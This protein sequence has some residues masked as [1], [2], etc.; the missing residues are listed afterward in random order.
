MEFED[1]KHLENYKNNVRKSEVYM[2]T[3]TLDL[4]KMDWEDN[5]NLW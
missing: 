4:L 5:N 3:M 1:N 2:N